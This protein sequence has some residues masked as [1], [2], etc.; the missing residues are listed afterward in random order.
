MPKLY[1]F[2]CHTVGIDHMYIKY[3]TYF[4]FYHWCCIPETI[5][6]WLG[7]G[8]RYGGGAVVIQPGEC[9]V[10]TV[11]AVDNEA[12]S[13]GRP[14]QRP[15][16]RVSLLTLLLCCARNPGNLMSRCNNIRR[17]NSWPPH[18]EVVPQWWRRWWWPEAG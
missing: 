18:V 6:T 17:V 8:V 4:I 9:L 1:I 7:V 3:L 15:A 14:A 10:G 12:L 16:S 5:C 11:A 13:S 2:C